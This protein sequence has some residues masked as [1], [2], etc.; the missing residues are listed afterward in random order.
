M[1]AERIRADYQARE[2]ARLV[3]GREPPEPGPI[4]SSLE[5]PQARATPDQE[6]IRFARQ[7]SIRTFSA[8]RRTLKRW[9]RATRPRGG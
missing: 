4:E 7:R 8:S 5:V 3:Q 1:N 9:S 2:Q 6:P